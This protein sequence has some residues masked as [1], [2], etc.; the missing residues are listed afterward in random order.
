M[1]IGVRKCFM[2]ETSEGGTH[3]VTGRTVDRLVVN[4]QISAYICYD[5]VAQCVAIIAADEKPSEDV[6]SRERDAVESKL[7]ELAGNAKALEIKEIDEPVF[8]SEEGFIAAVRVARHRLSAEAKAHQGKKKIVQSTPRNSVLPFTKTP[9]TGRG[10]PIGRQR[11]I[12]RY[13]TI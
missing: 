8:H 5:C 11:M 7:K 4:N 6:A 1:M 13:N 2:C 3:P 10:N 9:Q 12:I